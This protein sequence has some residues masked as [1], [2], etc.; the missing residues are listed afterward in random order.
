MKRVLVYFIVILLIGCKEV[1]YKE[2]QPKGIKKL[3]S[4]P[5]SLQGR[6]I[7]PD[8]NR[9]IRDTLVVQSNRYFASSDPHGGSILSDSL[10]LKYHEGFYFININDRP[11]WL[12][13]VIQQEKN[14]DITCYM[15]QAED[16]VFHD[17]LQH[18]SKE[19][20][21]DSTVSKNETLYQINPS[22]KKLISLI[23]KGYFKKTATLKKI[24]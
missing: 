21:V 4:I 14:G 1:T 22:S 6:Y 11:E 12:L 17:M 19:I 5:S 23:Q 3:H 10:L 24:Q 7:L 13:R 8:D 2:P 18:L 20:Q 16:S 15:L 9:A